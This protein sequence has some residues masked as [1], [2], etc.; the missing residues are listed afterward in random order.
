MQAGNL[1]QCRT[2]ENI[3]YQRA[4]RKDAEP[5]IR[6]KDGLSAFSFFTVQLSKLFL[7]RRNILRCGLRI[8]G[9]KALVDA[10]RNASVGDELVFK[11]Y[12]KGESIE[13]KV[14]VGEDVQPARADE[15]SEEEDQGNGQM[16]FPWGNRFR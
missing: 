15:K 11:V 9:S 10:V 1:N 16:S 12:R 14:I 4:R 6:Y 3:N 7:C 5:I 13:L 8:D 2:T